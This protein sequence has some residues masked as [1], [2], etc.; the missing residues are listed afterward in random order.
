MSCVIP[1]NPLQVLKCHLYSWNTPEH[2]NKKFFFI[3]IFSLLLTHFLKAFI[4]FFCQ[5]LLLVF[6][7][8]YVLK[9]TFLL[10]IKLHNVLTYQCL[11]LMLC[12]KIDEKDN[13]NCHL[14]LFIRLCNFEKI[15]SNSV[16]IIHFSM[17][18]LFFLIIWICKNK[19][20]K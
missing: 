1:Q 6:V 8:L 19:K 2:K 20:W 16:L 9:Y 10:I 15:L 12:C 18:V 11:C 7:C 3:A 4:S 17:L 13:W 14:L 5:R